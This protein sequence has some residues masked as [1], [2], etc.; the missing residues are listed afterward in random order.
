MKV[1]KLGEVYMKIN[2]DVLRQGVQ[3]AL[4]IVLII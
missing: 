3:K 1:M 4:M 2:G